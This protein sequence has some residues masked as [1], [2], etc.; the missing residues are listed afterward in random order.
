M[1][2]VTIVNNQDEVIGV[3]DRKTAFANGLIRRNSRIWLFNPRAEIFLQKRSAAKDIFPNRWTESA[4]G[5][6]D[7]GETYEQAAHRELE[8]EI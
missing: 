5:H 7:E 3:E 2:K 8:E 6:V 4:G 1:P